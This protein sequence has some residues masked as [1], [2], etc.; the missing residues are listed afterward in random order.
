MKCRDKTI[1]E[2]FVCWMTA[3]VFFFCA[4]VPVPGLCACDDC[5]YEHSTHSETSAKSSLSPSCCQSV[6]GMADCDDFCV[7]TCAKTATASMPVSG[8][9]LSDDLKNLTPVCFALLTSTETF[10]QSVSWTKTYDSPISR[11][12]VRLHLLLFV[13]L[14]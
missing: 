7:C 9:Q 10:N 3:A 6:S 11:L 14:I 5:P 1:K 13:L 2:Q 12:P 4:A 8:T